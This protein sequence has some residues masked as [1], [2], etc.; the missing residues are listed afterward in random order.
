MH[1]QHVAGSV[2][3]QLGGDA[4]EQGSHHLAAHPRSR[5]EFITTDSELIAIAAAAMIGLSWRSKNGYSTPAA[6]GIPA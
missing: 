6:T 2:L 5:F 4:A 1:D 3:D